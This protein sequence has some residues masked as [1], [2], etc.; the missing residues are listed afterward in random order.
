M[1]VTLMRP[2]EEAEPEFT[3]LASLRKVLE[4]IG[5]SSSEVG[6]KG[7]GVRN[8]EVSLGHVCGTSG[9]R[10]TYSLKLKRDIKARYRN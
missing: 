3:T 4:V 9:G 10:W 8:N 6:N 7:W 1:R 2:C 5:G